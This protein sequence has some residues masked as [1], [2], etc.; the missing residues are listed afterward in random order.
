MSSL[1]LFKKFRDDNRGTTAIVFGLTFV[2]LIGFV[3]LSVDVGSWVKKRSDLTS[4]ADFGSLAGARALVEALLR[5]DDDNAESIA[6]TTALKYV[7]E[8]GGTAATPQVTVSA[9]RP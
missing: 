2:A 8:N 7:S 6:R 9:T 3:G 5:K 1:T 4:S